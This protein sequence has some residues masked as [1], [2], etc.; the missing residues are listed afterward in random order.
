MKQ[1]Q[2]CRVGGVIVDGG[3]GRVLLVWRVNPDRVGGDRE[4][5]VL[6]GGGV[7]EGE[8][9]LQAV[10]REIEEETSLQVTVEH[11]LYRLTDS[12]S[13]AKNSE[14]IYYL[15]RYVSGT[16]TIRDGTP[17]AEKIKHQGHQYK[18]AWHALE[19]VANLKLYPDEIKSLLV[20]DAQAGFSHEVDKV[21]RKSKY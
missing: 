17:E 7:E 8:T 16:P 10:E 13:D 3:G 18:L 21:V 9:V 19:D 12:S 4:Y 5:Y 14:E 1:Q 2:R 11:E 15:C 6:P 20:R